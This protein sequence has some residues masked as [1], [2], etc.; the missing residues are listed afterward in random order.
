[1]FEYPN[2]SHPTPPQSAKPTANKAIPP[3]FLPISVTR[4]AAA[5]EDDAAAEPV[6]DDVVDILVLL[7]GAVPGVEL[8]A[9]VK[10]SR[11]VHEAVKPVALVQALPSVVF[12]RH[13]RAL[14]RILNGLVSCDD[15]QLKTYDPVTKFTGAH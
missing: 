13:G 9:A 12:L 15:T 7:M 4:A 10:E 2:L 5:D 8:E 11:L 3:M 6:V 14:E 1:V